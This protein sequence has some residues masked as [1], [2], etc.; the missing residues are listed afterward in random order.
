MKRNLYYRST[1]KREN[2]LKKGFLGY[3]QRHASYPRLLLEVFIRKDFGERYFQLSS[4]LW[5]T[6]L[7][8]LWPVLIAKFVNPVRNNILHRKRIPHHAGSH[9]IS[10]HPAIPQSTPLMLDENLMPHYFGWYVFLALFL[11]F[12]IIRR[13]EIRRS[14]SAYD[15]NKYS[16]S[17]GRI[18]PLFFKLRLPWRKADTRL[19]ETFFEPAFFFIVGLILWKSLNQSIGL[20]VVISSIFYSLGYIADYNTGDNFVMDK[21]DEM[22]GNE[23]L[24]KSFVDGAMDDA[25]RGSN[26]RTAATADTETRRKVLPPMPDEPDTFEAR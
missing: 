23:D 14:P 21:I 12:S 7:L 15:F 3:F 1:H 17:N 20:V 9:S 2:L 18:Y 4:A 8:A 16:L 13:A 6:F 19:I 25:T 5:V 24:K 11:V 10:Q 22:V 26:M